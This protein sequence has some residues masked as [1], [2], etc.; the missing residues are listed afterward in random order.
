MEPQ[1]VTLY[2]QV[3][4]TPQ[5]CLGNSNIPAIIACFFN[6]QKYYLRKQVIANLASNE[7]IVK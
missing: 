6:V 7:L 4:I 3:S 5:K 1:K 2:H